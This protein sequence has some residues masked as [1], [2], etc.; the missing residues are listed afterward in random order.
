MSEAMM[1]R[2]R[3]ASAT[4]PSLWTTL[5]AH[6]VQRI[7]GAPATEVRGK[8]CLLDAQLRVRNV[9]ASVDFYGKHFGMSL[10][11]QY[12]DAAQGALLAS[13]ATFADK[14]ALPADASSSEALA[15]AR[16]LSGSMVTF[17]QMDDAPADIT[18]CNGNVD[19]GRG[20]GHIGFLV[21]NLEEKCVE[22][23][24]MGVA[25]KKRP[26]EGRMRGLAFAV[27]LDG[28]WIEIIQ[29]GKE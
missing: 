8:P 14:T 2:R 16:S 25:F 23:E 11:A 5:R 19:P 9:K 12:K 1:E 18:Y 6:V 10:V 3:A 4:S 20:F 17:A 15:F 27:D 24:A 13:C 7:A 22:L 26:H 21:D 28:Y 29:R